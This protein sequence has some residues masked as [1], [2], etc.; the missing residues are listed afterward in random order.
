ML[1]EQLEGYSQNAASKTPKRVIETMKQTTQKLI[2]SDIAEKSLKVGDKAPSFILPN[3]DGK[4]ISPDDFK[5]PLIINFNRGSW[6][7]YCNLEV[8]AWQKIY[9]KVKASGADLV[10]ISPN[11]PEKYSEMKVKNGLDF[12]LLSDVGNKIAKQFGL[13][14]TLPAEL[15]SIYKQF[16]I[17]I[18][19]YNGDNSYE[20]PIP[21][22]YVVKDG[23]IIYSFVDPDY[24]KRAEPQEVLDAISKKVLV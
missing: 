18:P 2:K 23:I 13:V 1:K 15:I 10:A 8:A 16:G 7:P 14:F 21:A 6:C 12:E 3:L 9:D 5:G 19:L 22:T 4:L 20:L 11:V 17:D 24:T